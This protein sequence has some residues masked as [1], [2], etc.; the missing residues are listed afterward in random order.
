[1]VTI[2][3]TKMLCNCKNTVY[4]LRKTTKIVIS[5]Y[6]IVMSFVIFKE[7]V[8]NKHSLTNL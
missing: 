5:N 8:L 4:S 6:I 1:M 3:K 7:I 2:K